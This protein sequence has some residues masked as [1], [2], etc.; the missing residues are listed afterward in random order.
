MRQVL[1]AAA[2]LKRTFQLVLVAWLATATL[3]ADTDPFVGDWKF[4]PSKSQYTD[5]MKVQSLGGN[6]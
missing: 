2:M 4:N 1:E 6:N 5:V 3:W